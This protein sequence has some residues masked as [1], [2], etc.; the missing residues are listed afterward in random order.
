MFHILLDVL[1]GL[2]KGA[3]LAQLCDDIVDQLQEAQVAEDDIARFLESMQRISELQAMI[4]R[5]NP[6]GGFP[7]RIYDASESQK[8]DTACQ[9]YLM[10]L[11]QDSVLPPA[12]R[13]IVIEQAMRLDDVDMNVERLRLLVT[14]VMFNQSGVETV[15]DYYTDHLSDQTQTIH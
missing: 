2:Q 4:Q 8:L 13:E 5:L 3:D 7:I 11:E 15:L 9:S 10:Q 14:I 6:V 12:L 1:E